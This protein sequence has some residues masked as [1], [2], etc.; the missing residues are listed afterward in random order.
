V[1]FV[2]SDDARRHQ[3]DGGVAEVPEQRLQPTAAGHHVGVEEGDEVGLAC[4]QPRVARGGGPLAG[5][6]TQH[7]DVTVHAGEVTDLDRLRRTVVDHHHLHAAQRPDQTVQ[8]NRVVP[9]GYH[10][11]DVAVRRTTGRPRVGDGRVEQ[12]PRQLGALGV[13]HLEAPAVEHGLGGRG[14]AKQTG[15]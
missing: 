7:P 1:R 11:G 4:R 6:V 10:H 12:R 13:V 2:Q 9:H 3:R 5:L 14:Q 8:A 15:R